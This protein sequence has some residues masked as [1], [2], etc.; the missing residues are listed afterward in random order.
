MEDNKDV[1][2][3]T[4]KTNV[5]GQEVEVTRSSNNLSLE[6]LALKIDEL[7]NLMNEKTVNNQPQPTDNP[8]DF[9]D[10]ELPERIK[11]IKN[12]WGLN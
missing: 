1:K 3:E 11:K 9:T 6:Q 8:F 4:V 5:L 10:K 12:E 2:I 7:T